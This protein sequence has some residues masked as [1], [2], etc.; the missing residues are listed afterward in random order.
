MIGREAGR[1]VEDPAGLGGRVES[2]VEIAFDGK[3]M[4]ESGFGNAEVFPAQLWL[5][6]YI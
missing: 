4:G 3:T 6:P 1:R 5:K 2:K